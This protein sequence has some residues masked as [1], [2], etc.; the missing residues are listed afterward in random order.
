MHLPQSGQKTDAVLSYMSTILPLSSFS[1]HPSPYS[2]WND[3]NP[4][5]KNGS[6]C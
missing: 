3:R 2:T 4:L 1:T 5:V 6:G